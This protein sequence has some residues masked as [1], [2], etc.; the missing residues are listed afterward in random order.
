MSVTTG[1]NG[2]P[3][4]VTRPSRAEVAAGLRAEI[5]R[6][7][8]VVVEDASRRRLQALSSRFAPSRLKRASDRASLM[9]WLAAI[10][11][12]ELAKRQPQITRLRRKLARI[13]GV[14]A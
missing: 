12:E 10:G 6:L 8:G 5:A 3:P 13:E 14:A 11:D 9:S 4:L 2:G 7:Q 1:H